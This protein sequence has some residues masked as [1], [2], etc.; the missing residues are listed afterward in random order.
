MK[1]KVFLVACYLVL[2]V[3]LI[4][5]SKSTKESEFDTMN[6]DTSEI[7]AYTDSEEPLNKTKIEEL[8]MDADILKELDNDIKT[9][10]TQINSAM[11]LRHGNTVFEEY[12]NGTTMESLNDIRSVTKSFTSA[13]IGIAILRGDIKSV[14]QNVVEFFP[15]YITE[16]TDPKIKDITIKH[17]LTM[18]SGI[19]YD[20]MRYQYWRMNENP[21]GSL[22]ESVLESQPGEEYKYNDPGV[23]LLSGIITKVSGMS[24]G[25]YAEKYL[26]SP[27]GIEDFTWPT[28][29]Q[30][31][32]I[33]CAELTLQ[34]RDLAKF[35]QLYLNKGMWNGKQI[36]SS[37]W[38]DESAKKHSDGGPPSMEEYGY[39]WWRT[40]VEDYSAYFAMGYGGQFI[41]VIPEL[42]I[43]A[44]VTSNIWQGHHEENR[45]LIGKYVIPAAQKY[46]SVPPSYLKEEEVTETNTNTENDKLLDNDEPTSSLEISIADLTEKEL[47]TPGKLENTKYPLIAQIEEDKIY[48]YGQPNGVYLRYGNKIQAFDWCYLTPRFILPRLEKYDLDGDGKD[49]I[50]CNLYI[51]SG[52]GVSVEEMHVLKLDKTGKYV[53][54]IFN[55]YVEQIDN[56]LSFEYSK[57]ENSILLKTEN[58]SYAFAIPPEYKELVF[59]NIYYGNIVYFDISNSL[60]ISTALALLFKDVAPPCC[61]NTMLEGEILFEN[62]KFQIVNLQVKDRDY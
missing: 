3:F 45:E 17:L 38:I 2:T 57:S 33:G 19:P 23:H 48:L 62:N 5:C 28:D 51:G 47:L 10:Y 12:Y 21:I 61:T 56:L 42:D 55:D 7:E 35:G 20:F 27:L 44:V 43:V 54:F 60:K 11:V 14:E 46:I 13:L 4:G 9:N 25:E 59:D 15:E 1:S 32:N 53:D 18:T 36:I 34:T 50:I 31:N 26:F 30:G 6:L 16:E 29:Y 22:F 8:G 41:Y 49:E 40:K 52:T 37:E 39:L 58:S 24:A